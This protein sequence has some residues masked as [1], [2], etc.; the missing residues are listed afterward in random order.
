MT[1]LGPAIRASV[2]GLISTVALLWG[3]FLGNPAGIALGAFGLLFSLVAV[4][5][6]STIKSQSVAAQGPSSGEPL[7]AKVSVPDGAFVF[8]GWRG[9]LTIDGEILRVLSVDGQQRLDVDCR[10]IER[11]NFNP[12]NGLWA[13]RMSD[14]RKLRLRTSGSV[15]STDRSAAGRAVTQRISQLAAAHGRRSLKL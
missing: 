11:Y 15:L 14:G 10:Q 4:V 5:V 12:N 3:L 7:S 13:F 2:P 1:S 6:R 9:T 8:G